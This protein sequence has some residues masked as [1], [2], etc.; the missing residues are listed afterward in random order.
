ML[1]E[2][3]YRVWQRTPFKILPRKTCATCHIISNEW[4]FTPN[5]ADDHSKTTSTAGV[6][7]R[8]TWEIMD[9]IEIGM[10]IRKIVQC[11][12]CSYSTIIR[13]NTRFEHTCNTSDHQRPG[14]RRLRHTTTPRHLTLPTNRTAATDQGEITSGHT[15]RRRIHAAYVG[16]ILT[17]QRLNERL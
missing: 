12:C 15:V 8:K 4:F 10:C 14:Q 7:V 1:Y 3:L 9:I 6:I 13:I 17:D 2:H 16:P 11:F 5:H